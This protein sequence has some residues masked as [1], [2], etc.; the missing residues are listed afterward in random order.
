MK[1]S[2]QM[3]VPQNSSPL[4]ELSSQDDSRQSSLGAS[5]SLMIDS[6]ANQTTTIVAPVIIT[7]PVINPVTNPIP[8]RGRV[9]PL[10]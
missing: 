6:C 7:N 9:F 5:Q 8:A 1:K 2:D 3:I 10:P 4:V